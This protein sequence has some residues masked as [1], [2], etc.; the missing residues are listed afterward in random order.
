MRIKDLN[1]ILFN[2]HGCPFQSTLLWNFD[3]GEINEYAF[4]VHEVIIDKYPLREVKRM[5]AEIIKGE[6]VIVIQTN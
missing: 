4:G 2:Q 5:Q 3:G 6:A 1:G